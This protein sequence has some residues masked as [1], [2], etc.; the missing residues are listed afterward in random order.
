MAN[1]LL[2][3]LR[4]SRNSGEQVTLHTETSDYSEA[5][6]TGITRTE[7]HFVYPEFNKLKKTILHLKTVIGISRVIA[8]LDIP[9]GEDDD[10]NIF[11][12]IF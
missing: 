2:S 8:T 10:D 11:I 6:I 1:T 4:D 5:I 12:E 7:I 9:N 3:N